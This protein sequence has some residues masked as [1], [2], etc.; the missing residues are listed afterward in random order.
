[1]LPRSYHCE[2]TAHTARRR[3]LRRSRERPSG[4]TREVK[5]DATRASAQ[6]PS[7]GPSIPLFLHITPNAQETIVAEGR[8]E[9]EPQHRDEKCSNALTLAT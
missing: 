4:W 9:I 1:M 3:E 5:L 8:H 2:T 6:E 7:H